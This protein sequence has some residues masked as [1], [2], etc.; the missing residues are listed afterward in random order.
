[1]EELNLNDYITTDHGHIKL[2]IG[3]CIR[4]G[5]C[6]MEMSVRHSY[7]LQAHVLQIIGFVGMHEKCQAGGPMHKKWVVGKNPGK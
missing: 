4:C 7:T 6:G 5:H 3:S 2:D 1:M